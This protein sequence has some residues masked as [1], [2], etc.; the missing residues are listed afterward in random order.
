MLMLYCLQ[1]ADY[2]QQ[3]TRVPSPPES[4][5]GGIS[6]CQ[7]PKPCIDILYY[8][9]TAEVR[10][11]LNLFAQTNA[12]RTNQPKMTLDGSIATLDAPTTNKGML[13]IPSADFVYPYVVRNQN[14]TNWAVTFSSTTDPTPNIQYQIWFNTSRTSEGDEIFSQ[15][16]LS[17]MRGMDEA[18]ITI[19][20]NPSATVSAKI[21]VGIK[22]WPVSPPSNLSDTV[23]QNLGPV[24]FFCSI[25]VIFL[26]ALDTIVTE[27]EK[28]LRLGMEMTGL[29]PFVYWI[30]HFLSLS[31][32]SLTASLFT[33]CFG[34]AFGFQSFRNSDFF[35]LILTFFLLGES[36]IVMGFFISTFVSKAR[37]AMMVGIFVFIVGILFQSFVFSSAYFGYVWWKRLVPPAVPGFFS[38]FPFF[39]FGKLFMDISTFTTGKPSAIT[40]T[41]A[42]GPGLPWSSLYKPVPSSLLPFYGD[43]SVPTPPP[44]IEAMYNL[45]W[46]TVLYGFLTW[47]LD[48]VIPNEFGK[49]M[50]PWF[51]LTKSYWGGDSHK[52]DYEQWH[53]QQTQHTRSLPHLNDAVLQ[54]HEESTKKRPDLPIQMMHLRKEFRSNGQSR[55]SVKD[56][57]LGLNKGELFAL[58]GQNGAGKTTTINI[59]SGLMQSDSGD[60]LVFGY[61]VKEQ[62]H[63]I[64]KLM[65]ICPQYDVLF[66]DM[67]ARE[68][69][70]L[71]CGIKGIPHTQWGHLVQER[72][73]AVRLLAVADEPVRTYSGG[74]KRRL[75]VML[76]TIG[77]PQITFL[78]EPT[79]GMDPI[80]R[81]HVWKFIEQFKRNRVVIL[82]THSMEEAEVL[83]DRIAIM[84][85]GRLR[86][87]GTPTMLKYK[88]SVGYRFSIITEAYLVNRVKELISKRTR[89]AVLE[90]DG[91]GALIYQFPQAVSKEIPGFIKFLDENPLGYFKSWGMSETSL[92]QI[93]LRI[94]RA[95]QQESIIYGED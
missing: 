16:L 60:A 29:T 37:V 8:P 66:D 4:A 25:M 55:I 91:A 81:R 47:Y 90:D 22:S 50:P 20:N 63:C 56:L 17:F 83:G 94:V 76:A 36:M 61:S 78:D 26:N 72:L 75:S 46:N 57:C 92:E 71:F 53:H 14:T 80:N 6:R 52:V 31:L 42:V 10:S 9:D 34:L 93:F 13:S 86:A 7:G 54:E 39:N 79:T 23:V 40:G 65:G 48:L 68:H 2:A 38:I 21:D 45:I 11:Y 24:F 43:G 88:Y 41:Y 70:Q 35:V 28:R 85:H 49:R 95:N 5:L 69:I 59:L 77:D 32:E 62:M 67:S 18:I 89:G 87:I 1:Q 58:L 12:Q 73:S 84:A 15:E 19:L 44:P 27:K 3:R 74:M 33:T 30:S 82:T 51:F 64:R